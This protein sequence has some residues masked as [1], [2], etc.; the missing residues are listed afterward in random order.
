MFQ[1]CDC[2]LKEIPAGLCKGYANV[3][4]SFVRAGGHLFYEKSSPS[5]CSDDCVIAYG[6]PDVR[7]S[8]K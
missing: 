4:Y 3:L 6:S 7:V 8:K 5:W 2:T 1:R